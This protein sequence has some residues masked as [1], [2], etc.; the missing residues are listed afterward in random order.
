MHHDTSAGMRFS[1]FIS[2]Q[3]CILQKVLELLTAFTQR[4]VWLYNVMLQIFTEGCKLV[5]FSV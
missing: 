4:P 1:N 2:V 5:Q 3:I